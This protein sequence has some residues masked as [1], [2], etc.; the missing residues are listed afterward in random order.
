MTAGQIPGV[1]L[2]PTMDPGMMFYK[3]NH[4]GSGWPYVETR[5]PRSEYEAA[6]TYRNS[7]R[8]EYR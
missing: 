1:Q 8:P 6:Q 5:L 4:G 7:L 3:G 2:D